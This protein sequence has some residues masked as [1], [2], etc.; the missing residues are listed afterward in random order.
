MAKG[1]IYNLFLN[2]FAD[3]LGYRKKNVK[4]F[5]VNHRLDFI[6][7]VFIWGYIKGISRGKYYLTQ[8]VLLLLILT[9]TILGS[10]STSYSVGQKNWP[11]RFFVSFIS[12]K[13]SYEVEVNN[14]YK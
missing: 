10:T 11:P 14:I 8:P 4:I 7:R 6:K 12:K 9:I 5:G 3:G 2:V 1:H 13:Y